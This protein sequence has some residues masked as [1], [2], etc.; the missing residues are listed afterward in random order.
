MVVGGAH[1]G[2]VELFAEVAHEIVPIHPHTFWGHE[3]GYSEYGEFSGQGGKF[4]DG[5][6]EAAL[7]LGDEGELCGVIL[8]HG[9][10][11]L[12]VHQNIL[13][14][15]RR[16]GGKPAASLKAVIS[17]ESDAGYLVHR[18]RNVRG[19]MSWG[20]WHAFEN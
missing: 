13:V 16:P 11:C 2:L 14:V 10:I 20:P 6:L 5:M 3:V 1:C 12:E 7:A 15:S 8:D 17:S 19:L 4:G 9:V 18:S